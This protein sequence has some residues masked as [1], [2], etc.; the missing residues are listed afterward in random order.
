M[1]KILATA[2]LVTTGL[3][4]LAG[5]LFSNFLTPVLAMVLN[6]GVV[7]LGAAMLI[8]I[9]YLLRMHFINIF[10]GE[11]RAGLS[12]L[13]LIAFFFTLI[14]G[15]V[16]ST[17]NDFF[18]DLV[19]NIQIP[20]EAGLL[21]VLGLVLFSASL[22]L[23]RT[24]GW[25]PLS[26]SFLLSAVITLVFD[27]GVLPVASGSAFAQ[28]IGFLRRLPLAGAR[29]ILIGM[30]LGGLMVG[31]RVLLTLDRPYGEE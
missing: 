19:L 25:T 23:I 10:T 21:A 2:I 5:Y 13:T 6:W 27:S 24:Q 16:L 12:A 9:A 26:I 1:R 4:V 11:K 29:G 28:V 22:R 8:G 15:L 20:V 18:S 7:V 3:L 30:A 17:Q 31:L 14:S